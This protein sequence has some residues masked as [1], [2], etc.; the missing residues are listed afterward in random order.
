MHKDMSNLFPNS[1]VVHTFIVTLDS[2]CYNSTSCT[3]TADLTFL[4]ME[5]GELKLL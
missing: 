1:M 4:R 5:D 2:R 3:Q